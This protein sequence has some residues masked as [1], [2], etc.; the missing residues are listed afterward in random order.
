MI[1]SRPSA[2]H[3]CPFLQSWIQPSSKISTKSGGFGVVY[4]CKQVNLDR[5]VAVK[6]LTNLPDRGRFLREQRA[7]GKMTGHPDIVNLFEV[8][9]TGNGRPY[10]VMQY[11]PRIP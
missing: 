5:V 2:K 11:Y 9:I 7:M 8:G 1:R 3:A 6:V 10:I 4:R